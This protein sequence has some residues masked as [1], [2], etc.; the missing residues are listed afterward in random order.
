MQERVNRYRFNYTLGYLLH[1][2]TPGLN[3]MGKFKSCVWFG[4]RTWEGEWGARERA[5]GWGAPVFIQKP[6]PS[7][8]P[9]SLTEL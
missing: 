5:Q 8:D 3:S 2:E 6:Y 9:S 4:R 1:S 7:Q